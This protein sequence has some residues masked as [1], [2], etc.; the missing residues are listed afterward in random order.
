M[1]WN[2]DNENVKMREMKPLISALKTFNLDTG[3]IITEDFEQ[4]EAINGMKI[5][6][7]PLWKWLLALD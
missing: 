3:Y 5:L 4:T 2:I 6:F 7:I 1:C